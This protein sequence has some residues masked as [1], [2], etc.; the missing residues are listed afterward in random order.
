MDAATFAALESELPSVEAVHARLTGLLNDGESIADHATDIHLERR[1]AWTQLL[2]G[3]YNAKRR[4][5]QPN[6]FDRHKDLLTSHFGL[7][8]WSSSVRLSKRANS[9]S[10]LLS[11]AAETTVAYLTM[12]DIR[13]RSERWTIAVSYT[14]LTLPTKRIV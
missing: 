3:C 14:H 12:S 8:V 2:H 6:F 4:T 1:K 11:K 10:Q 5:H 9:I 13:I 7:Q